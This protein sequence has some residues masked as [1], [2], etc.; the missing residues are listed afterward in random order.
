MNAEDLTERV[1]TRFRDSEDDGRRSLEL[2]DEILREEAPLLD[3]S[4]RKR[5]VAGFHSQFAGLGAL[6]DLCDDPA[7]TDVL[8][9]PDGSVWV[10]VEGRLVETARRVSPEDARQIVERILGPIGQ[11]V[12]RS[13]PIADGRLADGSRVSVLVPPVSVDGPVISIRRFGKIA[14]GLETFAAR[15]V[16]SFMKA[17]I[18]SRANI[19]VYGGTGCGK[20]TLLN[21]LCSMLGRD[22]R[23][24]TI[25]DTAELQLRLP[26]V[27][28][29]EARQANSEGV[30]EIP[31]RELI[32]AALR[33]RPDRI[34]VGEV[35][36]AE[37][38][39]MI[40]AMSTG[41]DGS[42]STCHANT[43]QDA[44]NRLETFALLGNSSLPL[45]AVRSQ[46][47]SAVDLLIGVERCVG[48]RRRV[49][50][51][52][53]IDHDAEA[54]LV[55]VVSE[56]AVVLDSNQWSTGGAASATAVQ[57]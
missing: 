45:Q 46:V 52:D 43:A 9:N 22:E 47:R 13:S 30:G 17:A 31:I 24:I 18:V 55:R 54:G 34:I 10:E 57:Q 8:V 20:T 11:R 27:V 4:S 26:H 7:V 12:D 56:G 53:A 5:M 40:W 29:L 38:L 14:V 16:L 36:G 35:R 37:A 3:D 23:V 41:H 44:L 19:V 39:D 51:I 25:E 32:R 6:Q 1:A 33:M 42:L 48:G 21:G 15:D 2:L 50:S 49:H 28:R